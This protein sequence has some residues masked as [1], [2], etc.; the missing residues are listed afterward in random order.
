MR[1][2]DIPQALFASAAGAS[3]L[4]GEAR[5][6]A[7]RTAAVYPQIKSESAA[8]VTPKDTS[9]PPGNVRRYGAGD[10]V[11]H[12][13]VAFAAACAA[14]SC[15]FVP[16]GDYL[17][18]SQVSVDKSNI[19]IIG[20]EPGT[21][22]VKIRLAGSAGAGAAAF[23]WGSMATDVRVANVGIFLGNAGAAQIGL[24]FAELRRSRITN[25]YIEGTSKSADD[26]TAIQ[27]DGTGTYTGDVDVE[28]CYLTAHKRAVDVQR[29]CTTVRILNCE[30]YGT[31]SSLH[32][33]GVR[34]SNQSSG[35]LVS[36]NTFEGWGIGIYTEGGYVKQIGNYFEDN[37]AHWQWVR[38]A[39]NARI[40]NCSIGDTCPADDTAVYP[41]ND[42][43]S[44]I[45]LGQTRNLVD[46]AFI[47][48]SR[49]FRERGRGFNVGE[50]SSPGYASSD[51]SGGGAMTWLVL[52]Q[53][54]E[55]YRYTLVGS[56]MTVSWHITGS[57]VGGFERTALQIAIPA[58]HSAN[59][60]VMVPTVVLNNGTL[61]SGIA[62]VVGRRREIYIC[63]TPDRSRDFATGPTD[64]Y[65]QITFEIQ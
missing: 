44:C 12:D 45:V 39:G 64:V 34:I 9:Y 56:T 63:L 33:I 43:D 36:G 38:G 23:R 60:R 26:T 14:N 18:R 5:G 2:R 4:P 15:V 55:T 29:V 47:E 13:D 20:E 48:A 3:F 17:L 58:G 50:W 53:N 57:I 19:A 21:G 10:G 61:S 49:G 24:R 51:F 59:H 11:T 1:R 40:W 7:D 52:P 6:E 27:F 42:V 65:G 46:S 28:N 62:E 37:G 8:K 16:S 22:S 32:T 35:V 54:I 30:L 31:S 25:C 41:S